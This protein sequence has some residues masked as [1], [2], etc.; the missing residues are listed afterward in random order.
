LFG[1]FACVE[2]EDDE[3]VPWSVW[4]YPVD[5]QKPTYA[6]VEAEFFF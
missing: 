5:A 6:K 3:V 2:Y 4:R 1:E